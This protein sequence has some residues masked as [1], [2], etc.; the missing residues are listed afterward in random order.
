MQAFRCCLILVVLM[1]AS[2]A[3]GQA[4]SPPLGLHLAAC[5]E[6]RSKAAA[7]CGTYG[8]YENR[9]TKSGRIISL[10]IVVLK[11]QHPSKRAIAEIAGGPGE[12]VT[13]FAPFIADG[14]FDAGVWTLHDR[15][16][17]LFVDDRGMGQSNPFNCDFAPAG[18]PSSYFRQLW[19]PKL[20]SACLAKTAATHDRRFYNTNNA[21]DDLNDVRA[22]LGYPKIVLNGGSYGTFFSL[23]YMRRHPSTVESAVLDGVSAPHFQPLPGSPDGAQQ[24]LDDL[25]M[26]C[27]RDSACHSRFPEFQSHFEAV[28]GRLTRGSLP[29]PVNNPVTKRRETVALSKEVFVDQVRHALYVPEAAAFLPYITERAFVGDYAP[30]GQMIQTVS[31]G[32]SEGVDAGANLSYSCA[33][34]LPFIDPAE[35]DRAAAHSF[36]GDL[37]VRAQRVACSAW[38]VPPMPASFNDP[39]RSDIPVLLISASDDPATPPV[40]GERA[41]RYLPNG[42]ELLVKGAGHATETPCTDRAVVEFVRAGSAKGLDVSRCQ[43]DF[44]LPPFATSMKNWP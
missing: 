24:A 44:K 35:L 10:G 33:D 27:A 9:T 11:A 23:V 29:V 21:V 31:Q 4:A 12:I 14:Q 22:A 38:S 15:Y 43:A 39:V 28:L 20:V 5:T 18:D 3:S 17:I 8:L 26:K 40:Y 19:P 1:F 7:E 41:L 34:W 37:R 42:K 6:G 30:L 16:D 2:V 25:V 36:A 13:T 32:L